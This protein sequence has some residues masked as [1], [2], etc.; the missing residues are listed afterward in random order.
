MSQDKESTESNLLVADEVTI[1]FKGLRIRDPGAEVRRALAA[2]KTEIT[3]HAVRLA[4]NLV[5]GLFAPAEEPAKPKR[6]R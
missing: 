1:S 4:G 3:R 6:K 2:E 5:Q